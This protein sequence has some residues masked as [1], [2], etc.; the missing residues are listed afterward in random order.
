VE[1]C[2]ARYHHDVE[3]WRVRVLSEYFPHQAFGAVADDGATEFLGRGNPEA[4]LAIGPRQDKHRHEAAM[5][6]GARLIDLLKLGTAAD[7]AAGAKTVIHD[8]GRRNRAGA[9]LETTR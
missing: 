9:I 5:Q 6:P 8:T 3:A 4:C 1:Q 2:R 7:M